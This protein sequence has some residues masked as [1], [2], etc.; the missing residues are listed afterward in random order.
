MS[1]RWL[2]N[3][4]CFARMALVAPV[5]HALLRGEY[6]LTLLLFG[7]AGVSDGIDGWLAKTFGWTSSLGEILDPIAD[8][9]LLVTAFLTLAWLGLAPWWLTGAVVLRD[10]VIVSGAIAYH[11][12]AGGFE[13]RPTRASKL[14]TLLQLCYVLAV[15]AGAAWRGVPGELVTVIGAACFVTTVVS[16]LDYVIRY[17]RL[18]LRAGRG[19]AASA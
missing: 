18:A 14:N 15:I 16:G 3:A 6:L 7:A 17:A 10:V 5:V 12:L 4:I 2:P 11:L 13:G 8:K 1:L 19:P 9:L